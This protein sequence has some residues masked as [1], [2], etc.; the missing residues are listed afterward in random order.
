MIPTDNHTTSFS[1]ERC[2]ID[3][4]PNSIPD[5]VV[6]QALFVQPCMLPLKKNDNT[7]D[8][9]MI[10]H[11]E[12]TWWQYLLKEELFHY[13]SK[14]QRRKKKANPSSISMLSKCHIPL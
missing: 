11:D 8:T 6:H 14:C 10:S 1:H 12:T 3:I 13:K 7:N 9:E 2:N 4:V 5:G